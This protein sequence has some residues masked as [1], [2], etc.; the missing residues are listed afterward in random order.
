MEQYTSNTFLLIAEGCVEILVYA[1]IVFVERITCLLVSVGLPA[2]SVESR[3]VATL[4]IWCCP[5][6][7]LRK[8]WH[9]ACRNQRHHH[10][11]NRK[12]RKDAPQ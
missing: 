5:G 1:D 2:I 6:L 9:C 8:S 11:K 7:A 3:I 12:Y 10:R 4:A